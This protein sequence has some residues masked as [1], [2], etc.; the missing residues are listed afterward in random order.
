MNGRIQDPLW[1]RLA[2]LIERSDPGAVHAFLEALSP[3]ETALVVSR[4]GESERTALLRLLSAEEAADM[5]VELPDEQA[6][7]LLE[8]ITVAEAAAIV[9]QMPADEQADLLADVEGAEAEA[10]LDA[11]PREG[12]E[13][14]RRLLRYPEHSAGGIMTTEF[15][16]Y[17]DSSTAGDVLRDLQ[18]HSETYSDYEVQ[19]AYITGADGRLRG[20]LRM[21]DL[22]LS[23]PTSRV[24]SLMITDPVSVHVGASLKELRQVFEAHAYLGVPV[25]D[26]E[27]RLAGILDREDVME[28]SGEEA[29]NS[30]LKISGIVGGEELR[31]MPL[32]QRSFRRLAWLGPNIL[33]NITAA[34]VI[35]LY[36]ETLRA[37][38][39]LAVL[40]PIISDMSGC[41]GNQAVAVSI[42]ELTL[43][44]IRPHEYVRVFLKEAG[45]GLLN[46]TLLGLLLGTAAYL[47]KGNL[48]LG[49]VVGGA[50]ALNTLLSVILGG[51]IPLLLR[52]FGVDPALASGPILTTITD[53]CGFFLVLSLASAALPWL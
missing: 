36:Q 46:G 18:A 49:L 48:Y 24:A 26:D 27:G 29:R 7:D 21:R 17:P 39:A 9:G 41:S 20:V 1:K 32:V 47:W 19:Y 37:V 14:A 50:L 15:L 28:A 43:G 35:A 8:E 13:Q 34:S 2:G 52:R 6:A 51:S 44:L 38:I 16:A 33:L 23:R 53:M 40:L 25:V 10:I 5:L 30:F 4:L 3:A 22:L 11:M 31:S 12:A 45:L 42:R